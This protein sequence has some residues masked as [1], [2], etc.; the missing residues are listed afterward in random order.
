MSDRTWWAW[1]NFDLTTRQHTIDGTITMR[2]HPPSRNATLDDT[3]DLE[4]QL[5]LPVLPIRDL[6]STMSGPFCYIYA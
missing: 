2:N 5:G 6:T 1:Q 4:E 3:I